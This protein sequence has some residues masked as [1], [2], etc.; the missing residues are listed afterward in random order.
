MIR[1]APCV[2]A[3]ALALSGAPAWAQA[4][5]PSRVPVG[6]LEL[7][8]QA[9]PNEARLRA[10]EAAYRSGQEQLPLARSQ[11]FPQVAL[12]ASR[13]RNHLESTNPGLFGGTITTRDR[14]SGDSQSLSVRQPLYRPAQTAAV[15]VARHNVA[16]AQAQ[17]DI[18]YP[19][20][21]ARVGG[22]YLDVILA[23]GMVRYAGELVRSL[24]LQLDAAQKS[25]QAGSGTR[26]DVDEVLAQLDSALAQQVAAQQA[27][28]SAAMQLE[29]LL[30][31]RGALLQ[32]ISLDQ[33]DAVTP[34]D[35]ER[36]LAVWQERARAGSAELRMLREQVTAAREDISRAQ[37]G[38]K[39]TVDVVLQRS[40]SD[41]ENVTRPQSSFDQTSLAVQL[42]VPLYSGGYVSAQTRQAVAEAEKAEQLLQAAQVELDTRVQREFRTLVESTARH[43]ALRQSVA[44]A[45]T[46]QDSA[47]RS[48][49]AGV[50]TRVDIA[51]ATQR[52]AEQQQL[53]LQAGY[54]TLVS[55]LRL[56]LLSTGNQAE[57]EGALAALEKLLR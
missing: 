29:I 44:S 20:F 38:H 37:A 43:R 52:W 41:S 49:S 16:A 1:L 48:F 14:Y 36:D 2:L 32:P 6:L 11:L 46:A 21:A 31:V 24:R 7:Y 34:A 40:K 10:A 17:R 47:E 30:G 50:R 28:V 9:L 23:E 42:N 27:Q 8:R 4:A 5:A 54:S 18:E 57:V 26:T 25:M 19:S 55:R 35:L 22:T 51:L 13:S 39:P 15:R 45:R 3:C 56:E 53:L 12:S 33:V